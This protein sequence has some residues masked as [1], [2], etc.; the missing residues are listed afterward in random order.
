MGK[1]ELKRAA[2]DLEELLEKYS[3]QVPEAGKC[4]AE[5]KPIIIKAKKEEI[6]EPI[7]KVPCGYY[8]HEGVLRGLPELEEKYSTFAVL[9]RGQDPEEIARFISKL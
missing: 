6:L 4:L 2:I 7:T 5:L 1:A 9:L 3:D 8:F